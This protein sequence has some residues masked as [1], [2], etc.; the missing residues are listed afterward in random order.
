METVTLDIYLWPEP[1][2]APDEVAIEAWEAAGAVRVASMCGSRREPPQTCAVKQAR[3]AA[4]AEGLDGA[5][6]VALPDGGE[7][8]YVLV[9]YPVP[10][11]TALTETVEKLLD[12]LRTPE[13]V[14][15]T[16]AP[17]PM[18]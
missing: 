16:F 2:Q 18:G 5:E 3:P 7:H 6:Q 15:R 17:E 13:A 1:Y 14:L 9:C 8:A 11:D 10:E 12:Q 4:D